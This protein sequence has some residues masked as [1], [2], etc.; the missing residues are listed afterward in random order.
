MACDSC[1][2][3]R[4][5]MNGCPEAAVPV[6]SQR[7]AQEKTKDGK[8]CPPHNWYKLS[9]GKDGDGNKIRT[10]ACLRAG[11]NATHTYRV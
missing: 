7:Y 10:D 11:C 9:S 2:Q 4:G 3:K 8:K 1:G 6:D 5:H